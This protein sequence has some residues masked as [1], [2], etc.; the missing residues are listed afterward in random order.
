MDFPNL[1]STY[2]LSSR[3]AFLRESKNMTILDLAKRSRFSRERIERIESGEET[4]LSI[5][6]RQILARALG[7]EPG[8]LKDVESS[9]SDYPG[10]YDKKIPSTQ[11]ID[12]D[13]MAERI[14]KGYTDVDCPKCGTPL[15]T[16]V[17]DACDIEGAP[18]QFARAYCPK[19]PF[20]LR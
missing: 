17:E 4:W 9:P 5:S 20:S 3:V 16:S 11:V 19:C 6:D 12:D 15:K 14:L 10:V 18:T 2:T 13:A 7:V 8:L 1:E